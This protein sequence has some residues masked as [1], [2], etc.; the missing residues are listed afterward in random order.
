MRFS[1]IDQS[2]V[3]SG[4]TNEF[5]KNNISMKSMLQKD[6]VSNEKK[7]ATIV[8]TTHNCLEKDMMRAL[9][10][11]NNLKFVLKKTTY[12]RIENFK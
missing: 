3:I 1:T 7:C 8:V 4:N 2:G 10:K 11:I 6:G 12:M 5:K 9:K